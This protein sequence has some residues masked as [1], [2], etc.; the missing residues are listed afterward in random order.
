MT[1]METNSRPRGLTVALV[2]TIAGGLMLAALPAQA[3][4]SMLTRLSGQHEKIQ[5]A[6][7]RTVSKF[8][9][10]QFNYFLA[11]QRII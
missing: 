11:T 7:S 3:D 2:A 6:I 4:K 10:L 9:V 1:R 8:K 5:E